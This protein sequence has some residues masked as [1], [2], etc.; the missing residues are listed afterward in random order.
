LQKESLKKMNVKI[1][2]INGE[3]LEQK[4]NVKLIDAGPRNGWSLMNNAKL[5]S[6]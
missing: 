5:Y 4:V 1:I 3:S 2:T 6:Y